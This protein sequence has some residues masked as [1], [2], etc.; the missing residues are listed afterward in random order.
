[1]E[2]QP[3]GARLLEKEALRALNALPCRLGV[4]GA[5]ENLPSGRGREREEVPR[6]DAQRAVR[7]PGAAATQEVS[8]RCVCAGAR[9]GRRVGGE[10]RSPQG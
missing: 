10:A 2:A 4:P 6:E 3:A 9:A 5:A 7:E 8:L 1:M